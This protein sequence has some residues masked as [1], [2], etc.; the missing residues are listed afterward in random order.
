MAGSTKTEV[1]HFVRIPSKYI[2]VKDETAGG[3]ELTQF[4]DN[5]LEFK[6]DRAFQIAEQYGFEV[7][8]QTT[9]ITS[10]VTE[11]VIEKECSKNGRF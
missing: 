9:V 10:V 11:K 4:S 6:K 1:K 2:F 8:E 7:I 5:A 3:L